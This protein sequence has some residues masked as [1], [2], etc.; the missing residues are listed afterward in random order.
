MIYFSFSH[1]R[2]VSPS[3]RSLAGV[4]SIAGDV[5]KAGVVSFACVSSLRRCL[6]LCNRR[7]NMVPW[8]LLIDLVRM[9]TQAGFSEYIIFKE[10]ERRR[11]RLSPF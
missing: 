9:F 3:H 6:H 1:Y 4:V 5:S 8:F 7:G 10:Y 2:V 11:P